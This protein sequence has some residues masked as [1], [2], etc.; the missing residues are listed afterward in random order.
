MMTTLHGFT[1]VQ[2]VVKDEGGGFTSLKDAQVMIG[3]FAL[4]QVLVHFLVVKWALLLL[5][6]LVWLVLT[7]LIVLVSGGQWVVAFIG[8]RIH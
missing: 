6:A 1:G 7:L 2:L 8:A 3:L 4:A 5:S